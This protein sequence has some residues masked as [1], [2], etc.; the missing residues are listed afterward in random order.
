VSTECLGNLL[1]SLVL[2]ALGIAFNRLLSLISIASNFYVPPTIALTVQSD[3]SLARHFRT[4]FARMAGGLAS[5]HAVLSDLAA[6]LP[7]PFSHQ[8]LLTDVA[9]AW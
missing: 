4:G 2:L 6:P 9:L 1:V 7:T 5:M 3:D 8:L